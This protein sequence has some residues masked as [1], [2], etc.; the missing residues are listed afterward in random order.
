MPFKSDG[1]FR[2]CKHCDRPAR[3]SHSKGRHSGYYRTCGS[4]ECLTAQHRSPEVSAK[5]VFHQPRIC[6]FCESPYEATSHTQ[7]WCKAC[8]PHKKARALAMRYGLSWQEYSRMFAEQAGHCALCPGPAEAVDHNHETGEIRGLLCFPCNFKLGGLDNAVWRTRADLY[9]K[10][11]YQN[12]V[13][14]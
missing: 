1:K 5:K 3:V 9:M 2:R 4:P 6:E 10:R 13:P 12:P 7:R 11:G 14:K 8:V